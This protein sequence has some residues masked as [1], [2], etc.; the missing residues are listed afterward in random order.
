VARTNP[1]ALEVAET[2]TLT[3]LDM[4]GQLSS[5]VN[6]QIRAIQEG[7]SANTQDLNALVNQKFTLLGSALSPILGPIWSVPFI[8]LLTSI[9]I[10]IATHTNPA[11]VAQKRRHHAASKAIKQLMAWQAVPTDQQDDYVA[12]ALKQFMGERF[13][14]TSAA[15]TA[16]D[17]FLILRN[18]IED[19]TL[20]DQF[21][22]I[23]AQ[24]EA[25]QYARM[26]LD[27]NQDTVNKAMELIQAIH[28]QIK[29]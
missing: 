17:C 13:D 20:A 28:K 14:R 27:M 15:L 3:S 26:G 21:K 23:L 25:S 12:L 18:Q 9:I 5:P 8:A 6:R 10:R 22:S 1:I 2:K 16:E 7:L 11:K 29:L 19:T 4:E 24:C